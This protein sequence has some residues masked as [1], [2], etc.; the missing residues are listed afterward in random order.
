MPNYSSL[1]LARLEQEVC[2]EPKYCLDVSVRLCRFWSQMTSKCSQEKTVA[3]EVQP[4]VA[5]TFLSH[6]DVFY[7]LLQNR[8][9][10][11]RNAIALD[12]KEAR[13][14]VIY[15]SPLQQIT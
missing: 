10:A 1:L 12:N 15:A 2:H 6:F 14:D 11:T 8:H 7:D 9:T 5:L 4:S 13:C 3:R